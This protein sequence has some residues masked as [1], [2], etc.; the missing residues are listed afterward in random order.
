MNKFIIGCLFIFISFSLGLGA[1]GAHQLEG[2]IN[3]SFLKLFQKANFYLLT[4]SI[5]LL[6]AILIT[7]KFNLPPKISKISFLGIVLFCGG[8][9]SS[10]LIKC[11]E[12]NFLKFW[13]SLTPIGGAILILSWFI[14]GLLFFFKKQNV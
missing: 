13:V 9:Y 3:E 8:M 14:I 11:Y 10:F 1:I 2:K 5:V 7:T 4:Q 12:L 6:L